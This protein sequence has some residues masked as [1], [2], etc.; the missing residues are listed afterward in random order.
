MILMREMK[1]T[2]KVDQVKKKKIKN[3]VAEVSR[4]CSHWFSQNDMAWL[5]YNSC[6]NK[7]TVEG[8]GRLKHSEQEDTLKWTR[9]ERKQYGRRILSEWRETWRRKT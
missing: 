5:K 2:D 6:H 7:K 4:M 3:L 8:L 1:E 9:V